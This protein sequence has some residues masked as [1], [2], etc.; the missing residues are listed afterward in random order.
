MAKTKSKAVRNSVV[1]GTPAA[2][3]GG[4]IGAYVANRF[5]IPPELTGMA[6]SVLASGTASFIAHLTH[7]AEAAK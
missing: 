7:K 3:V 4:A 1:I 2:V 5:G 6:L